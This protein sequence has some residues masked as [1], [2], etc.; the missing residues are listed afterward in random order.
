MSLYLAVFDGGQDVAGVDVGG[1]ADFGAFREAVRAHAEDGR[2]A[3][4]FPTLMNHPD[5][6]GEWA[7]E[8]LGELR[9]ELRKLSKNRRLDA[10]KDSEGRPLAVALLA[11]TE[12]ALQLRQPILFQ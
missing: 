2:W 5:A 6:D 8:R 10:F 1:Y 11:L 9:S 12:R 3:S 7:V 4:R